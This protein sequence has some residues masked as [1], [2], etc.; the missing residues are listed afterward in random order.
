M[1]L[2]AA[3][4]FAG[5]SRTPPTPTR[6]APAMPAPAGAVAEIVA[7]NAAARGGLEA[8]H[9][10]QTMVWLGH[11]APADPG[12]ASMPF[13]MQLQRPNLVRF[14]VQGQGAPFTRVFD[15]KQGWKVRPGSDGQPSLKPFSP[16]EAAYSREEFVIDG[17]L[18]DPEAKD[19]KVVFEGFDNFEGNMAYRLSLKLPSGAE[20]NLWIDTKTNL[21]VRYDRPSGNPLQPGARIST[22]YRDYSAVDG[23]QIPHSIEVG[24]AR[25]FAAPEKPDRLLIDKVLINPKL[26]EQTFARP[27]VRSQRSA[28]SAP[29]VTPIPLV[30]GTQVPKP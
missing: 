14:E 17:P 4:A 27:P 22:Y 11:T 10:V 20:R 15:G 13:A 18:R 7:R 24:V 26:T 6:P 28:R 9:K 19:V 21:E 1:V 12:A 16:E 30:P 2:G 23:L 3:T 8:W 29:G 25:G 5:S